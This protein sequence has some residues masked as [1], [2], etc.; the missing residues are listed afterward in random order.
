MT[1]H[2]SDCPEEAVTGKYVLRW[3]EDDDVDEDGKSKKIIPKPSD[4][5]S[6]SAENPFQQK[7]LKTMS[8]KEAAAASRGKEAAP[9]KRRARCQSCEGCAGSD[10][11]ECAPC[12]SVTSRLCSCSCSCSS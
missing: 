5:S 4:Y 9:R 6:T 11:Q 12:R 1:A 7:Y 10:C 3:T 2:K 8:S